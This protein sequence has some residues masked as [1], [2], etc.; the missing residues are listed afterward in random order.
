MNMGIDIVSISRISLE[1][2]F[3]G[4]ILSSAERALYQAKES[5]TSRRE[6]LAGRWAAK[7]AF[8]KMKE[9]PISYNEISVLN[10]DNGAPYIL[11]DGREYKCSISHEKDYAVALAYMEE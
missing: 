11:Y 8:I 5:D 1:D 6:F 2:S 3:I 10:K 4:H 7:E 9:K